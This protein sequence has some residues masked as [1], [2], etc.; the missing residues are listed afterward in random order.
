MVVSKD[1]NKNSHLLHNFNVKPKLPFKVLWT[2]LANWSLSLTNA[3]TSRK[4]TYWRASVLVEIDSLHVCLSKEF[5]FGSFK[6]VQYQ[7]PYTIG[8]E[9]SFLSKSV[10]PIEPSERAMTCNKTSIWLPGLAQNK[11]ND[12]RSEKYNYIHRQYEQIRSSRLVFIAV[13]KSTR[14]NEFPC[15]LDLSQ[16]YFKLVSSIG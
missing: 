7:R 12:S 3:R 16:H 9:R 11:C 4:S 5:L 1:I 13:L 6:G 10:D 14:H 15:T 2:N 8:K